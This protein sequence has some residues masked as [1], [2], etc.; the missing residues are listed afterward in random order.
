MV[1][2]AK[3]LDVPIK[4]LI[5]RAPGPNED[6]KRQQL[7]MLGLGDVVL[8]GI[9]VA[10][11]LRFDLYLWYLRK[12]T[13]QTNRQAT[14]SD[15]ED[16]HQEHHVD[17]RPMELVKATYRPATGRWG[18]RFWTSTAGSGLKEEPGAF[19]KPYFRASMIGYIIGLIVTFGV[20]A[21]SGHAQPAL[22]YLVP[23]VLLALWG[24]AFLKGEVKEMWEFVDATS[25]DADSQDKATTTTNN[26]ETTRSEPP[27]STN[28]VEGGTKTREDSLN[29]NNNNNN[30]GSNNSST[31]SK[32]HRKDHE[33]FSIAITRRPYPSSVRASRRLT[34][35]DQQSSIV[36]DIRN[37][38]DGDL[39]LRASRSSTSSPIRGR[40]STSTAKEKD[41]EGK[42]G[43]KRPRL[44]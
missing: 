10:L 2:V 8:P 4:L 15:A 38:L 22:L 37:A 24:L 44:E 21:Y 43:E 29:N 20:L 19:P 30:K 11:A 23:G 17:H 18:E 31:T 35:P 40:A 36:Q 6:P 13:K 25:E 27:S 12:Q 3:S 7:A 33:V 14:V 28:A 39:N 1:T 41:H 32:S 9:M 16:D 34:D 42:H 26:N 5:P